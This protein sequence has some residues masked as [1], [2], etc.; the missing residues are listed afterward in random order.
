[1]PEDNA[2]NPF[3]GSGTEVGADGIRRY[4]GL[5]RNV[6]VLLRETVQ[7]HPDRTAVVEL[8]GPAVTYA[9]LWARAARVAGGLPFTLKVAPQVTVSEAV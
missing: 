9:E 1:M 4:T 2:G 7:R 3:D 6:V 8:D 5:Q